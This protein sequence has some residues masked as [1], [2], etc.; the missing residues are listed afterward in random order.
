MANTTGRKYGG[1]KA[2]TPNKLTEEIRK[3]LLQLL[4]DNMETL[5][6]DL[7]A[8]KGKERADILISLVR[9]LTPSALNPEKLNEEQLEQIVDYLKI[10]QNEQ[11]RT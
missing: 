2:G 4:N 10:K 7:K 6:D 8:M 3:A 1:R 9:H 11:K 5:R